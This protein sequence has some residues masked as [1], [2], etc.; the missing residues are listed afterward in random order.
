MILAN[1]CIWTN[2]RILAVKQLLMKK[3]SLTEARR[4]GSSF[5]K[6][7]QSLRFCAVLMI[8]TVIIL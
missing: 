8:V 1:S 4:G 3:Q 7:I 6:R 5:S 2:Y